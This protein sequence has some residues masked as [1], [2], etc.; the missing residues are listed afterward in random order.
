MDLKKVAL[1]ARWEFL[2]AITR[3]MYIFAVLAMPLI[4]GLMLTAAGFSGRAVAQ[5]ESRRPIGVIDRAHVIDFTA[6]RDAAETVRSLEHADDDP[7]P[8]PTTSPAPL[9]EY[10]D[11]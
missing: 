11:L 4:Y 3:R 10:S 5:N 9:T 7:L 1:V 8:A 2:S 6:A